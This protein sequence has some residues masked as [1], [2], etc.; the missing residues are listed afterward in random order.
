MMY[1]AADGHRVRERLAGA[2]VEQHAPSSLTMTSPSRLGS[3]D[4]SRPVISSFAPSK[5]DVA[6]LVFAGAEYISLGQL[7]RP[8]RHAAATSMFQP[9]FASA[10]VGLRIWPMFIRRRCRGCSR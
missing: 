3:V 5:T 9:A 2:T 8:G 1:M 10:E 6:I 4:A 7:R